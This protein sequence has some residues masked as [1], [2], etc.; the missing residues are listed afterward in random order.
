MPLRLPDL[1]GRAMIDPEFLRELRQTPDIVLARYELTVEE[2]A[3]VT[4]ALAHLDKSPSPRQVDELKNT[5]LR[6]VAT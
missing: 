4:R 5:L 2:R 6:R 3:V 1:V